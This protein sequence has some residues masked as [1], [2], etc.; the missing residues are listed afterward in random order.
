MME[1]IIIKILKGIKR[2]AF[3]NIYFWK[4]LGSKTHFR[5]ECV[6]ENSE[7]NFKTHGLSFVKIK[8]ESNE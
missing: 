4:D 7:R 5:I 2:N 6:F 1:Y 8:G 3:G